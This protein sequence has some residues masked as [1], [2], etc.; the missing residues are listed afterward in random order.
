MSLKQLRHRLERNFTVNAPHHRFTQREQQS[1]FCCH[2]DGGGARLCIAAE[3]PIG[4]R[5]G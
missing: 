2:T 4:V 3:S 1:D 5:L